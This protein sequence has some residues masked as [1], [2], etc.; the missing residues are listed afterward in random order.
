M[1]R[2]TPPDRVSSDGG[3]WWQVVAGR[4]VVG[5]KEHPFAR[6]SSDGGG[7]GRWWQVGRLW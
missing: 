1:T 5:D 7:G 3:V 6:V 2:N 4:E